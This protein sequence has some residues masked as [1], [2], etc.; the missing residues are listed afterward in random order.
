[1]TSRRATPSSGTRPIS[2][3]STTIPAN[4]PNAQNCSFGVATTANT[5]STVA[6]SLHCGA[7]R[8]SGPSSCTSR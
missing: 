7:T 2:A 5:N 4:T 3:A 8:W 6:A 1:M